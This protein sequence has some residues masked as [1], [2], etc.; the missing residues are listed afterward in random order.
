MSKN[1]KNAGTTIENAQIIE[2]NEILAENENTDYARFV[3][4]ADSATPALTVGEIEAVEDLRKLHGFDPMVLPVEARN[5]LIKGHL[6]KIALAKQVADLESRKGKRTEKLADKIEYYS[7]PEYNSFSVTIPASF[8][9][10]YVRDKNGNLLFDALD[11]T[12]KTWAFKQPIEVELTAE[13]RNAFTEL[14]IALG[15]GSTEALDQARLK[16]EKAYKESQ[17]RK[18]E[19]ANKKA[20]KVTVK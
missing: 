10:K 11:F 4:I 13:Q 20:E 5:A 2:R 7:N 17:I 6:E 18:A 19:R 1:R 15:F 16:G 9:W 3:E 12:C 14:L 8:D